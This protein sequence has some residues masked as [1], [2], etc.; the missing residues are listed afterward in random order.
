MNKVNYG[1]KR[2]IITPEHYVLGGALGIS[3]PVLNPSGDWT[4][5]LP[6]KEI[7]RTE[8]YDT[9]NCTSYGTL[10]AI[11]TLWRRLFGNETNWSER[12]TGIT[13]GTR[14]PGNSP[15][16]VAEAIRKFGLIPESML[17]MADAET[18]DDYYSPDPMTN[19]LLKE[20]M[21]WLQQ[22]EFKHEWVFND[23]DSLQKKQDK[24][25]E[26]LKFSPLGASVYGWQK[27]NGIYM[28]PK[29]AEDNHWT[30][31]F[32]GIKGKKWMVY[33]SYDDT[34]KE[35]AWDYDFGQ[36]KRYYLG[37][38]EP[39]QQKSWIVEILKFFKICNSQ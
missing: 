8:R 2:D 22:I 1:Y 16:A 28:K 24:M 36:A 19:A 38:K 35:L 13:A 17:A 39:G 26:A 11:E 31:V 25:L 6:I 18:L 7:Q 33:D 32:N 5:S 3:S 20:G 23:F 14:P 4:E 37:K 34:I 27:K 29:N 9:Y 10:N 12:F 21:K 30:E 15:H